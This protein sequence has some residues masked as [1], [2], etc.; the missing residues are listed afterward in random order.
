SD[1][2][3]D[4]ELLSAAGA[5]YPVALGALGSALGIPLFSTVLT[6]GYQTVMGFLSAAV[7][8]GVL[9][10]RGLQRILRSLWVPVTD[11]AQTACQLEPGSFGGFAPEWELGRVRHEELES[12]LFLT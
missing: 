1:L 11:A 12:P 2:G 6:L 4:S 3:V 8:L 7:R 10:P 9:G 5:S